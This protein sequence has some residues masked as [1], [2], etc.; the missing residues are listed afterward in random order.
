MGTME[1]E[2]L[3]WMFRTF[4]NPF[5]VTPDLPKKQLPRLR[6]LRQRRLVMGGMIF[7]GNHGSVGVTETSSI[8]IDRLVID[9]TKKSRDG[10]LK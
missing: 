6:S 5:Q 8:G 2:S 7:C 9:T 4:V 1:G 3:H 10:R